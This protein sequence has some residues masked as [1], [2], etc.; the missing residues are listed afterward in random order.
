[1]GNYA[2]TQKTPNS[3]KEHSLSNKN[4]FH[5]YIQPSCIIE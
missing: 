2:E 3:L 4:S 1:L 5:Q